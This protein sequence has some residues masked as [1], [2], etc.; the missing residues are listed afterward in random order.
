M[1]ETARAYFS[2]ILRC[3]K[4]EQGVLHG[5]LIEADSRRSHPFRTYHQLHT[6][7]DQLVS[8]QNEPSQGYPAE[9]EELPVQKFKRRKDGS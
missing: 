4:D 9:Q 7:I 8:S 5:V 6:K 2:F 1:S 3:W